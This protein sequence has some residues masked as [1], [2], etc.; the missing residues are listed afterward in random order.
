[1]FHLQWL[2]ENGTSS[3]SDSCIHHL[4]AYTLWKLHS[5]HTF[6]IVLGMHKIEQFL[7]VPTYICLQNTITTSDRI[8]TFASKPK[9]SPFAFSSWD[10]QLYFCKN[11]QRARCNQINSN[12]FLH[13]NIFCDSPKVMYSKTNDKNGIINNCLRLW[14]KAMHFTSFGTILYKL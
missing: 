2:V 13:W 9:N 3:R 10:K 4:K 8:D 6:V 14:S 7:M 12:S 5:Y 11:E 1:M